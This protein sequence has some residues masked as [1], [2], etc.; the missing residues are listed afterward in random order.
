MRFNARKARQDALASHC[1]PN[2]TK[3][4]GLSVALTVGLASMVSPAIF[5]ATWRPY[6]THYARMLANHQRCEETSGV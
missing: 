3:M 4:V 6:H 1:S 5:Y 2:Q